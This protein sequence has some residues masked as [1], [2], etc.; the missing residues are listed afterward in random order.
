MKKLRCKILKTGDPYMDQFAGLEVTVTKMDRVG[1]GS[2]P[3]RCE[4][5]LDEDPATPIVDTYAKIEFKKGHVFKCCPTTELL[6]RLTRAWS[7]K[8]IMGVLYFNRFGFFI[9][10]GVMLGS[11]LDIRMI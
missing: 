5:V 6:I 8:L 10:R 7:R 1:Y 3:W 2:C 4:C 11:V 9:R